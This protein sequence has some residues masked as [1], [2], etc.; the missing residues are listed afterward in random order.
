VKNR[1]TSESSPRGKDDVASEG[2]RE[3]WRRWV[4]R[5]K[6]ETYALYLAYTDPR[7]PWYAKLL[8]AG[9]VAYAVSPIDLIPD[10]I[11]V[12]GLLDD[13]VIVPLGTALAIRMVPKEVMTECRQKARDVMDIN[14]SRQTRYLVTAIIIAI[15]CL[16]VALVVLL[17]LRIA[18]L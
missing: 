12:L 18:G 17:A 5:L 2:V 13:L 6:V 10:F 8:A 3:R 1:R 11:P 7:T 15:W 16:M 14:A 9:V 4:Q